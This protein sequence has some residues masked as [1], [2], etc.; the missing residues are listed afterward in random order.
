MGYTNEEI[1]QY[2]S[3]THDAERKSFREKHPRRLNYKV[4]IET[5]LSFL[6]K[7]LNSQKGKQTDEIK[8]YAQLKLQML[9]TKLLAFSVLLK[10][11]G[12]Y[13]AEKDIK[14]NPVVD[15]IVL[16]GLARSI[17]E[18]LGVFRFVYLLPDDEEK[19]WIAFNLWKRHSF[20]DNIKETEAKI[21]LDEKKGYDVSKLQEQLR[22]AKEQCDNLLAEILRTKY[23]STHHDFYFD[24][25]NRKKSLI[26]LDE[27]PKFVSL[28]GIDRA[29]EYQIPLKNFVFQDMYRILSHYA[30]PSY[31]AEFQFDNEFEGI[32]N[33]NEGPYNMI[34]SVAAILAICFI[35]SYIVYDSTIQNLLNEEEVEVFNVIYASFCI[36][37]F[38]SEPSIEE[39]TQ[40][41]QDLRF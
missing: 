22:F 28:S 12:V 14:L 11:W 10:K 32:G 36:G 7:V 29:M 23:A 9:T 30:H 8:H 24:N 38:G 41:R 33:S 21:I 27:N 3:L 17:Y 39:H 40:E 15:P 18:S 19:K 6:L 20:L 5:I 37:K 1:R 13:N 31:Q 26:M 34:V 4:I 35:S 2:E 25:E 16:G